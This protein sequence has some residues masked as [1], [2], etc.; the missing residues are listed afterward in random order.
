MDGMEL[1]VVSPYKQEIR[2]LRVGGMR[3]ARVPAPGN[4]PLGPTSK[5]GSVWLEVPGVSKIEPRSFGHEDPCGGGFTP[6]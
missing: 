1:V 4:V 5:C 3:D 6:A 2:R